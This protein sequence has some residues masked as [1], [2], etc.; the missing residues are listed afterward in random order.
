M[1]PCYNDTAGHIVGRDLSGLSR[2]ERIRATCAIAQIQVRRIL[3]SLDTES[4][5]PEI[6]R[7]DIDQF[8]VFQGY[9]YIAIV[10][11]II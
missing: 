4:D 8:A 11:I 6:F 5:N 9:L 7:T 2:N 3:D 10:I 1:M